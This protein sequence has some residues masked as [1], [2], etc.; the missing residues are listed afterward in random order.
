MSSSDC[1]QVFQL[2]LQHE[3]DLVRL[4]LDLDPASRASRFNCVADDVYLLRH[5]RK[6]IATGT[7][8]AGIFVEQRLRGLVE[9]YD[10]GH[11][12][13]VETAFL[14]EQ[15]WRRQGLGMALL[16]AAMQ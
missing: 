14:V 13:C 8:L 9:V 2:G 4:L 3:R 10:I 15:N 7:W 16:K 1:P 5:A 6:A 12:G 11:A